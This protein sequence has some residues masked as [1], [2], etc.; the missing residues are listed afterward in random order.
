MLLSC[1]TRS[2]RCSFSHLDR[3]TPAQAARVLD[4]TTRGIRQP[5]AAAKRACTPRALGRLL[6]RGSLEP[7][8]DGRE[9][10]RDAAVVMTCRCDVGRTNSE[11]LPAHARRAWRR[12]S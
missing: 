2:S 12:T 5:I 4:V 9:R 3:L 10:R 1:R 7:L 11:R 8:R 6:T